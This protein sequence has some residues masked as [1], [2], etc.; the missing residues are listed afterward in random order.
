M[1]H[2]AADV[3]LEHLVEVVLAQFLHHKATLPP[4]PYSPL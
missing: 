3:D 4:F 2:I 1:A